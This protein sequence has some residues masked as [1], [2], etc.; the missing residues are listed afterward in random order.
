[1][2]MK[3]KSF[4]GHLM[5]IRE[6]IPESAKTDEELKAHCVKLLKINEREDAK[7]D[8]F[9]NEWSTR[10][11]EK[12]NTAAMLVLTGD[13]KNAELLLE[14]FDVLLNEILKDATKLQRQ[15]ILYCRDVLRWQ[16]EGGVDFIEERR[17]NR[18]WNELDR[19]DEDEQKE[20]EGMIN[21]LKG[22]LGSKL[23]VRDSIVM[24]FYFEVSILSG[25]YCSS[26]Y[27]YF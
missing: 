14:E 26:M 17:L 21:Y 5:W 9:K 7:K 15:V 22:S 8:S 3:I 11:A 27:I 13:V 10:S 16:N 18:M 12:L 25:I 24:N 4:E 19:F 6:L 1:M 23:K 20:V 2:K